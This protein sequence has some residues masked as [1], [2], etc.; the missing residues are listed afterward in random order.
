MTPTDPIPDPNAA[1]GQ[2]WTPPLLDP[3]TKP[4]ITEKEVSWHEHVAAVRARIAA[5]QKS[6]V[7]AQATLN[8]LALPRAERVNIAGIELEHYNLAHSEV[9]EQLKHPIEVGGTVS[10]A[11]IAVALLVFSQRETVEQLIDSL[12][13]G[14]ARE[15][16]YCKDAQRELFASLTRE[17]LQAFTAWMR[18]EFNLVQQATGVTS[19]GGAE[20]NAEK[21]E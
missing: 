11:D 9:L 21:K 8:I 14:K 4:T 7:G 20:G 18:G 17:R 10:N 6:T 1:Q 3:P 13:A 2:P 19:D 15:M 12:G 16:V 5:Q